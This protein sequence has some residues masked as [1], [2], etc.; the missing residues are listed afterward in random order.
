MTG[1]IPPL[2]TVI[3]EMRMRLTLS[4]KYILFTSLIV[5]VVMGTIMTVIA[6]R[7]EKLILAQ[8]EMQA[9]A[10]FQQ[11]VITR[12]WVA[13]HS[14]VFVEA[15]PWVDENPFLKDPSVVDRSG[16]KY[17]RQNPAMVTKQLSGYAQKQSNYFFHITSLKLINP[18]N[19]PD[20][21]E[22]AALSAFEANRAREASTVE[23]IGDVS[24]FRYISP[25]NVEDAC[26]EC[27][28]NQGYRTGDVL[29]A[30]S[31][32]IPMDSVFEKVKAN[33]EFLV[34]GGI[35]TV[36]SLMSALFL[37]TRQMVISPISR[38][39]SDMQT[40]S[41]DGNPEIPV[42][43]TGDE[44]EDLSRSF[45]EMAAALSGYH[46]CLQEKIASATEELK[47]KN[48][49]LLRLNRMK[50]DSI[51][52][53]SHELRTPL[54]SIKGAMDYLSLRLS[55]LQHA[56]CDEMRGFLDVVKKNA[57][58]LIRLV[59]NVLD[60][61]RIELGTFEIHRREA[62]LKD[63]FSE[64]VLSFMSQAS[65]KHVEIRLDAGDIVAAVDEDRIRQVLI[66]LI[67]NALNFSPESS[68]ITVA[69]KEMEGGVFASVADRGAGVAG[70]DRELIF[71]Q[72]Y[73]KGGKN[74]VG[75]GLAICK[76][77]I[78]AHSGTIG[79]RDSE[80]GGS[81][82]FF[83]LPKSGGVNSAEKEQTSCR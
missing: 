31:V 51:A 34:L 78:E 41:R 30:I 81:C 57:E 56:D 11:I 49:Q 22:Q 80:G 28:M 47:E 83:T 27:H 60:Y 70:S 15:L 61:E 58:R 10:L 26:L 45:H 53:I 29:G 64:V 3:E 74:G 75:L 23:K 72:F 62:G 76:G 36:A 5:L 8:A 6:V 54:T 16:K 65:E 33:R 79:V 67:S 4:V 40:F 55:T 37:L 66:N 1:V 7:N 20:R 63:I 17:V 38:I 50:S 71:T 43:K 9:K 77:I 19:A 59:N 46:T 12:R 18:D 52:K 32:S 21:F 69:L 48:E 2:R 13:D 35:I 42:I 44:V 14:G 24:Y 82:F 39:R 73:S 68:E 25:L